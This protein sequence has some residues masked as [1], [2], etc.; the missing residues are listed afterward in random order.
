MSQ[1][2]FDFDIQTFDLTISPHLSESAPPRLHSL[3]D[4]LPEQ[5]KKEKKKKKKKH[6]E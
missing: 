5:K 4:L 2:I 6:L 1:F 3:L